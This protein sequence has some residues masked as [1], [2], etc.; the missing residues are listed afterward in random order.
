MCT[1]HHLWNHKASAMHAQHI[2][3]GIILRC[4]VCTEHHQW[5][6]FTMRCAHGTS[7]V[8]SESSFYVLSISRDGCSN[9]GDNVMGWGAGGLFC[10]FPC[11]SLIRYQNHA[12]RV[13]YF[14]HL[15]HIDRPLLHFLILAGVFK[16]LWFEESFRKT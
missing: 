11:R 12:M 13:C 7:S 10:L 3:F 8:E 16:F 9:S 4:D 14:E 6:H 2:I 15:L 1:E 5:N